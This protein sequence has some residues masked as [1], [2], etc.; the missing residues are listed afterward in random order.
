MTSTPLRAAPPAP[1]SGVRMP[2]QGRF[3]GRSAEGSGD[4]ALAMI[5]AELW[6]RWPWD[7]AA[8]G[9]RDGVTVRERS[10]GTLAARLVAPDFFTGS[11]VI[12][13][14]DPDTGDVL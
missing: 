11:R 10:D 8:L 7:R 12:R 2:R 3:L 1:S 5:A 4:L 14:L 6:T 13:E 9:G